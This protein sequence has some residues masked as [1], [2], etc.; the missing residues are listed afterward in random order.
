MKILLASTVKLEANGISKFVVNLALELNKNGK[1]VEV[2]SAG[3]ADDNIKNQL[4]QNNI[5][6]IE[7]IDRTKKPISYLLKLKNILVEDNIGI[8]HV[9]GNSTTMA[10]E[11]LAARLAHVKIRIA[12]SHNT[13]TDH[14]LLNKMLRPLFEKNVTGRLACNRAAGKWLFE[15][16]HFSVIPNGIYLNDYKFNSDL[17]RELRAKLKISNDSIVIGNVG[18]FNYQKNQEFL[19]DLISKMN[20]KYKLVLIGSG[21]NFTKDKLMVKE[22]DLA[23][24]VIFLGT[25][26]NVNEYLNIFDVFV[27]PSRFEGQPFTLIESMANGLETIVSDR[28][29]KDT[30]LTNEVIYLSLNSISS[31]MNTIQKNDF[32]YKKRMNNSVLY[33]K[34]LKSK[35]YDV[36][37][38]TKQMLKY[39]QGKENEY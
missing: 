4:E 7:I 16:K 33:S 22:K 31:W 13:T 23:D 15:N 1:A 9:N 10:I 11:L 27:L 2:L 32:N 35:G 5:K 24:K 29:S 8:L 26:N 17:R 18:Y 34:I 38:N 19:I 36:E 37:Y 6:V 3:K 21:T 28:I 39:Y 25:V 14:P 20:S 30:D 12:H